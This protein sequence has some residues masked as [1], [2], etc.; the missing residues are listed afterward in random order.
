MSATAAATPRRRTGLGHQ[1]LYF[2]PRWLAPMPADRAQ[3]IPWLVAG[4]LLVTPW[5][6]RRGGLSDAEADAVRAVREHLVLAERDGRLPAS[7]AVWIDARDG[8]CTP[9]TITSEAWLRGK[10]ARHVTISRE[11]MCTLRT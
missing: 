9:L 6:A 10:M 3:A 2:P 7:D 11:T 8:R 4:D 1:S 5:P